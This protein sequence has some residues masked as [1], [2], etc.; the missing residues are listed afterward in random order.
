MSSAIE[1][2]LLI[3]INALLKP[4]ITGVGVYTGE[5]V[6]YLSSPATNG[7]RWGFY[8]NQYRRNVTQHLAAATTP[9]RLKDGFTTGVS[10]RCALDAEFG[11]LYSRW[12]D[13]QTWLH[14]RT[15]KWRVFHATN[16]PFPLL[17]RRIKGILT[18]HDLLFC[19]FPQFE[20]HM[21]SQWMRCVG[22]SVRRA[23][24]IISISQSTADDMQQ[25]FGV[26][27][28]KI[29]VIYH[30]ADEKKIHPINSAAKASAR[31]KWNL[32]ER[33][34]LFV[35]TLSVH[36]NIVNVIK[37]FLKIPDP[38]LGLVIV[39]KPGNASQEVESFL[40]QCPDRHRIQLI[41]YLEREELEVF[42]QLA[43][44]FLFP[45]LHE[46]FGLPVIEALK[47]RLPVVTSD[48][49][50]LKELFHDCAVL[51][52]PADPH[53][54]AREVDKLLRDEPARLALIEKGEQKAQTLT[55]KKTA[56]QTFRLYQSLL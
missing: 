38:E 45:S 8:Y 37:A 27:P 54:I 28:R 4:H 5:L 20:P 48:N 36:K 33:F 10:Y 51:V 42:Y 53:H 21:R 39:G 46:G 32:P 43:T 23:D 40:S 15:G 3:D 30:G 19:R 16:I 26:D 11:R 13:L 6:R 22:Q 31:K 34:L 47:R 1:P 44:I 50:S 17:P 18:I 29:H 12:V 35:S 52:N 9:E 56:E 14:M 24:C 41:G 55:W 25:Y 7:L 49:S 2:T